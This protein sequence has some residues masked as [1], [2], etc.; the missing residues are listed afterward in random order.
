M[1]S[2]FADFKTSNASAQYQQAYAPKPQPARPYL[3]L[4]LAQQ[5]AQPYRG[6]QGQYDP[7]QAQAAL[8]GGAQSPSLA[9]AF[10]PASGL[11]WP[12]QLYNAVANSYNQMEQQGI[13][14][15]Q[16]AQY[17]QQGQG[18]AQ[19]YAPAYDVPRGVDPAW[20]G[21][22]AQEHNGRTP[23]QV[24]S[25]DG[26]YAVAHALSDKAWGDQFYR[27]YGRAP[28]DYDWKASYSQRQRAFYGG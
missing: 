5:P 8:T 27:T 28:S 13:L 23:E 14:P 2:P 11:M 4:V 10:G 15:R 12:M 24:Y 3:P 17:Q 22:F 21:Q 19:G 9:R 25:R 1:P 26:E 7:Q 18:Y 16:Q 6:V 20:W